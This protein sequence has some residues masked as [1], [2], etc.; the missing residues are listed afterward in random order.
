MELLAKTW[1]DEFRPTTIAEM[2]LPR[3]IKP[4]LLGL[5]K[6]GV[7]PNLLF[8]GSPGTGKT[9]VA[10]IFC[11]HPK[12]RRVTLDTVNGPGGRM[13]IKSAFDIAYPNMR[14]GTIFDHVDRIHDRRVVVHIDESQNLTTPLKE[15]LKLLM[16]SQGIRATFIFTINDETKLDE[17]LKSRTMKLD[18]E[19][20]DGEDDDLLG[21]MFVRC[22]QIVSK[23][24]S[25][26]SD[27][28]IASLVQRHFPDMRQILTELFKESVSKEFQ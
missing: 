4:V 27:Q 18:F 20:R 21:Q 9:S 8:I 26:L 24:N 5:E 2:I 19:P 7:Y 10:R 28:E 12:V 16:E 6:T 17:A 23:K 3:R 1:N 13:D 22:K 15:Q 11:S 14:K 25:K